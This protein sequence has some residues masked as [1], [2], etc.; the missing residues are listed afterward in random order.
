MNKKLFIPMVAFATLLNVNNVN[1]ADL[2]KRFYFK[3]NLYFGY[4]EQRYGGDAEYFINSAKDTPYNSIYSTKGHGLVIGTGA[5]FY[6]R[7]N[8]IIH[9][10]IGTDVQIRIPRGNTNVIS[11]DTYGFN[12]KEHGSFN[13]KLGTKI[14]LYKNYLAI[15]PYGFIGKNL[16]CLQVNGWNNFKYYDTR[17]GNNYG[18]GVDLII[19]DIFIMGFEYRHGSNKFNEYDIIDGQHRTFKETKIKTDNFMFKIGVQFL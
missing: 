12:I 4:T 18:F 1:A 7:I 6:F 9:P 10:F 15:A 2:S 8:S 17:Y 19:D 11:V 5:S 14:N 13:L 3:S 16:E